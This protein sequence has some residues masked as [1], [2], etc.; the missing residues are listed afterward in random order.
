[1]ANAK[2]TADTDAAQATAG[3]AGVTAGQASGGA[4]GSTF[5]ETGHKSATD[6]NTE[7][8][9]STLNGL[10]TQRAVDHSGVLDNLAT[11]ALQNAVETA[12]MVAKQAVRHSDLAIDRQW[13]VN[14]TDAFAT[15]LA[16]RV[17]ARLAD[18]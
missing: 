4:A 2:S 17:A 18:A 5:S 11:Q 3:G 6:V 15:I 14:E 7:E 8:A 1:M 10:Y 16:E 9:I 13:N 12:N